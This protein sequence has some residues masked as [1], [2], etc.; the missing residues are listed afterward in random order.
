MNLEPNQ[1]IDN[2]YKV[3]ERLDQ[4]GMGEV[5]KAIDQQLDDEVV[6]KMPLR[7][8]DPAVLKRFATEARLMRKHSLGNPNILDIQSVGNMQ[9]SAE[10]PLPLNHLQV[11]EFPSAL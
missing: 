3:L 2:R 5:W 10:G 8:S 7:N 4:G 11:K 6:L 9:S 1:I